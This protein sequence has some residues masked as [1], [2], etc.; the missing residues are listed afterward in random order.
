MMLPAGHKPPPRRRASASGALRRSRTGP[1]PPLRGADSWLHLPGATPALDALASLGIRHRPGRAEIHGA[2]AVT[3]GRGAN[4]DESYLV[5][6]EPAVLSH[7]VEVLGPHIGVVDILIGK[8]T[9]GIVEV[10]NLTIPSL[11]LRRKVRIAD[12]H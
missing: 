3:H 1:R 4:R 2:R 8:Q 9:P 6:S 12:M 10:Q 11:Q 5:A 7:V